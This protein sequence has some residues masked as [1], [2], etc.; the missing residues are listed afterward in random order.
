MRTIATITLLALCTLIGVP[1]SADEAAH[2]TFSPV[3]PGTVVT[4]KVVYLSGEAKHSQ[5]RAVLSKVRLGV[6]YGVTYYQWYLSIYAIDG[7]TYHLRYQ[8]P[9][10]RLP[11][12]LVKKAQRS[13]SWLLPLEDASI[14]GAAELMQPGVQQ[15]VVATHTAGADCGA[16]NVT[17]YAIDEKTEK[18]VPAV[19]IENHC[20]LSAAIVHEKGGDAVK[21]TGPYFSPTAT[22]ECPTKSKATAMLR[23]RNGAWIETPKYF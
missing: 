17:I 3:P 13:H 10:D 11:P 16:A 23:Y 15:L 9:R 22:C 8:S 5:W 6:V 19:S 2:Q 20:E 18:V 1:G 12:D 7:T 14:V 21:L 4:S